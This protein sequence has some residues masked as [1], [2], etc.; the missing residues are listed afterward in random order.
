MIRVGPS[1]LVMGRAP[2]CKL[3][4]FV[5]DWR[6][7]EN[8]HPDDCLHLAHQRRDKRSVVIFCRW[9]KNVD[10][11]KQP[12][13]VV[14]G[15]ELDAMDALGNLTGSAQRPH[16]AN[17]TVDQRRA[18][19]TA[20][21]WQELVRIRHE[22]T[23]CE[24]RLVFDAN[25]CAVAVMPGFRPMKL[26]LGMKFQLG[27]SAQGLAKNLCFEPQLSVVVDVLV[28]AATASPEISAWRRNPLRRSGQDV[29]EPGSRE[30][31]TAFD[32]RRVDPLSRNHIG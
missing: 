32:D 28:L 1:G 5:L 4:R 26:N 30:S 11:E 29:V 21:H 24:G 7:R 13:I 20:F 27:S 9:Q 18:D 2:R 22:I 15:K 17:R 31:G 10:L 12:T 23:E 19:W 8:D 6:S 3:T 14:V 25:P 16:S